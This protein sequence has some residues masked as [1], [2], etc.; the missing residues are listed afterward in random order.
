MAAAAESPTSFRDV[1]KNSIDTIIGTIH[2][3]DFFNAYLKGKK[4]I[5]GI[6]QNAFYTTEHAKIS[7]LL[8]QLQ[9]KKVHIAVV[10][11]EYGGTLGIVTLE[12]ILEELVGEIYDEHDEVINYFKQLGEKDC[13]VDGNAPISDMFE[14]FELSGEEDNFDANTVSGWVIEHLGE[15]PHAGYQFEYLNLAIEVLKSTVKRVLQIKVTVLDPLEK[16]DE[17]NEE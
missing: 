11:D 3:K 10:L 16:E 1:Y 12:D 15:I 4:G 13:I 17:D 8:R 2:E 7:D 5:D 6:M 9:K 14:Y